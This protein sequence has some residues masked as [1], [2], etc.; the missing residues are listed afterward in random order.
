MKNDSSRAILLCYS[1]KYFGLETLPIPS[2]DSR[3]A[4]REIFVSSRRDW[5]NR[6][7]VIRRVYAGIIKG[8]Q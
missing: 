3:K 5:N 4:N 6:C 7:G 8:M 1:N 2:R